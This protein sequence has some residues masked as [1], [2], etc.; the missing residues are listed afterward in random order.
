MKYQQNKNIL[1]TVLDEEICVFNPKNAEYLTFNETASF[2]WQLL[3]NKVK[4][5]FV[6]KQVNDNYDVNSE[7]YIENIKSF[8]KE[9]VE[10]ELICEYQE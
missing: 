9:N 10:R 5:N 2:I 8:I 3:E 1:S 4:L 6:F 7:I